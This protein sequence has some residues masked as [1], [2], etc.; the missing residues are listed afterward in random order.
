MPGGEIGGARSD[1]TTTRTTR[2]APADIR[3][4]D[5]DDDAVL[6]AAYRIECAATATV[7]PGWVPLAE[8][9]RMLGWRA[10][11]GWTKRLVGAHDGSGLLGFATCRTAADTPGSTWIDV[12][13]DPRHQGRGIGAALAQ[14]AE[15]AAPASTTRFV[16]SA[17]RPT[18]DDVDSLLDGFA[19]PL[20][21][22][23]ATTETVVELDLRSAR[24]FVPAPAGYEVS[25]HV[26]GVPEQLREQV[27][28]IKGLVDAEAPNGELGWAET[29]VSPAEYAREMELWVAQGRA[30]IESVAVDEAGR[31]AA[32]TCLVA[33]AESS[34]PSQV[35]G[36]SS[37]ASTGAGVSVP[38]SSW[39]AC[40]RR[41]SSEPSAGSGPA[42]TTTTYGCVPSTPRSVSCQWSPR[43]SSRSYVGPAELRRPRHAPN[44]RPRPRPRRPPAARPVRRRGRRRQP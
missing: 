19:R 25:T 37:S 33:A 24:V 8:D 5:L 18:R 7:R 14:A 43:S 32:W 38:R 29:P 27:G 1:L 13:V 36:P 34:R 40:T 35:E 42:A 41:S 12:M 28:R 11:T 9:A 17:Y 31:V 10:D 21:Y 2:L 39:P 3:P 16:A 26:N 20:D 22:A 23:V 44:H 30:A 6:A 15:D 4:L